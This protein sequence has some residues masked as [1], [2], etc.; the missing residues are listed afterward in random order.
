[1]SERAKTFVKEW[2][3]K[4]VGAEGY[5][6]DES[7]AAAFAVQCAQC[8]NEAGIPDKELNDAFVSLTAVMSVAIVSATD[9]DRDRSKDN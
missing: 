8:A 6:P 1:M 4:N 9:N 7:T 5:D 3:S 2:V